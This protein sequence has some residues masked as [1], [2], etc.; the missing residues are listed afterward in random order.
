MVMFESPTELQWVIGHPQDREAMRL[1]GWLDDDPGEREPPTPAFIWQFSF[2]PLS[3][4]HEQ[5]EELVRRFPPPQLW[6]ESPEEDL[7]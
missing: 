6:Y 2:E 4:T 7:F 3:F 5:L 1:A